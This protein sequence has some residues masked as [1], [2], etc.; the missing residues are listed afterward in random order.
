MVFPWIPFLTELEE[1]VSLVS[2]PSFGE[3]GGTSDTIGIIA[4]KYDENTDKII[5]ALV[6]T[7]IPN[8]TSTTL[9]DLKDGT[10]NLQVPS[11]KVWFVAV[12]CDG[13]ANT[14]W[15]LRGSATVDSNDGTILFDRT[16]VMTAG[17][18][19]TTPVVKL[20]ANQF[21]T[22]EHDTGTPGSIVFKNAVIVEKTA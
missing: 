7:S 1:E 18:F 17:Q 5:R 4:I 9:H 10:T 2:I 13:A 14:T 3:E 21:L 15:K 8:T 6:G 11:G 20:T 19:V 22:I 12:T 16:K